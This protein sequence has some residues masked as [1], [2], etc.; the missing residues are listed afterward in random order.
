MGRA[1]LLSGRPGV[2]KTTVVRTVVPRL[3]ARAGGFYTEE[4]RERGQRTGFRL[5]TLDGKTGLLA[6]IHTSGPYRVGK[7]GVNLHDLE[8]V[9]VAALWRAMQQP[10]VSVI[11][12][13]EIGKMELFSPAFREAVL[14][15]LNSQKVVLA[16]VMARSPS[17]VDAIK[18][19]PGVSLLE[20]TRANREA[21]PEQVLSWLIE[22]E[23]GGTPA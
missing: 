21:L 22:K 4:V 5:V 10:G 2:G 7:Y 15:A 6:S 3:G 19:R 20:V 9:G 11:V 18:A 1:L 13:D 16:T 17:W 14:A 12:I 8:Q 23:G